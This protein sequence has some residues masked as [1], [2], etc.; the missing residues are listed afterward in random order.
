MKREVGHEVNQEVMG[1]SWLRGG[2]QSTNDTPR[3][4]SKIFQQYKQALMGEGDYR[5]KVVW[6]GMEGEFGKIWGK[7]G[8]YDRRVSKNHKHKNINI[9]PQT[10]S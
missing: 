3:P 4:H 2:R 6:E 10:T 7:E 5:C 8:D 1:S 9:T